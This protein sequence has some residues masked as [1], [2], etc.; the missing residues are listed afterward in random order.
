[1]ATEAGISGAGSEPGPRPDLKAAI[2]AQFRAAVARGSTV[3][4]TPAFRV[5]VWPTPDPFYRNVAV[6]IR[7]PDDWRPAVEAMQ[8]AFR[9]AGR[10]ARL[11][12]VAEC[13]PDLGPA[14][15]AAG[16]VETARQR[17]MV[18]TALPPDLPAGPPIEFLPAA[19]T[20]VEGYLS[21]VL[22]AFAQPLEPHALADEAGTLA[23]EIAAGRCTIAT[24]TA[25]DRGFLA[26]AG[27]IGIDPAARGWRRIAE[28][29]GVWTAQTETGRGLATGVVARLVES[30]LGTGGGLVWLAAESERAAALYARVGFRAIGWQCNYAASGA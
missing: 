17:L 9:T 5:H 21:A 26:G 28:L 27:L 11:E 12:F 23:R 7:R 1:M 8:A 22:Q 6:P 3:V 15:A 20:V 18:M 24:V 16:L 10:Q 30:F 14:L 29:A 19:R 4:E 13:W 2:E 25:G